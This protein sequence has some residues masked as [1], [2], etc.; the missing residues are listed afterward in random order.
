MFASN[1]SSNAPGWGAAG[2]FGASANSGTNGAAPGG[3]LFGLQPTFGNKRASSS[4]ALSSTPGLFGASQA[5]QSQPQAPQAAAAPG[6]SGG[7]FGAKPG[8]L[9]GSTPGGQAAAG[10]QA[11]AGGL[12][13]GNNNTAAPAPGQASGLFGSN[14]TAA[15]GTQASGGLF[16]SAAAPGNAAASS[17]LFGKTAPAAGGLFGSSNTA[18]PAAGGLFGSS[19][20]AAPAAGGQ[21]GASPAP[22]APANPYNYD[23]SFSSI[24]HNVDQMPRSIT[25]SL[26]ADAGTRKRP[27][28][29]ATPPPRT[30]L[31]S[32][33]GQTMRYLRSTISPRAPD[34][35]MRGIFTPLNYM[36][37]RAPKS[38]SLRPKRLAANTP[39]WEHSDV[40]RLVIRS[41]PRKFHLIDTDKVFSAKRRRVVVGDL[42]T[43]PRGAES[44]EEI[45]E[46]RAYLPSPK[47]KAP[48]SATAPAAAPAAP[49]AAPT[50]PAP[51]AD[52]YWCSPLPQELAKMSPEELA[53]VDCFIVGRVGYGQILYQFPVDLLGLPGGVD[54]LFGQVVRIER[55]KVVVYEGTKPRVG[56]GLNVPATITLE[57]MFPKPGESRHDYIKRLKRQVGM[58]FV[59]YDPITGT[60]VFKVMHFSV[61]GLVDD[62]AALA[63]A[64]RK[65][66]LDEAQ[67]RLEATEVYGAPRGDDIKRQKMTFTSH[68]PGGWDA[69]S[70]TQLQR[71]ALLRKRRLVEHELATQLG[72]YREEQ[73][74]NVNDDVADITIDEEDEEPPSPRIFADEMEDTYSHNDLRYLRQLVTV[75]PTTALSE[76]VDEKAFEPEVK[77]D[78][79]FDTLAVRP[80]LAVSDDWVVQL[81]LS[82]DLNSSLNPLRAAPREAAPPALPAPPAPPASSGM[83]VARMDEILFA[84]FNRAAAAAASA[85]A[86]AA[87]DTAGD[88]EAV[89]P[90]AV[91]PAEDAVTSHIVR[92]VLAKSQVTLRANGFPRFTTTFKIADVEGDLEWEELQVMRLLGLLVE[93]ESGDD[94][95]PTAVAAHLRQLRQRRAVG[96]WLRQ[97]NRHTFSLADAVFECVCAGDVEGAVAAASAAGSH[98]LAALLTVL[99]SHDPAV[100]AAARAQL[101]GEVPASELAVWRILGGE[102]DQV[103]ELPW[104]VALGLRF[105]YGEQALAQLVA[106]FAPVESAVFDALA[107]GVAPLR[108][109][110]AQSRLTPRCRWVASVVLQ[111]RDDAMT[112]E[113]ARLLSAS[114]LWQDAI[115][116]YAAM[117]DDQAV[118]RHVRQLVFGHVE[119]IEAAQPYLVERLRVPQ[120]VLHEARALH[121]ALHGRYVQQGWAL[122]SA[123]LWQ[124]VHDCIAAHVGPAAVVLN[125]AAQRR[126]LLALVDRVP[127]RGLCV[128]HWQHGAGVY[129]DY[130]EMIDAADG[131]G[132]GGGADGARLERLLT[133]LPLHRPPGG[134]ARARFL[135]SVALKIMSK[136]VGDCA[137]ARH[138][139]PARIAALPLGEN[140]RQYF[141][142]R[143]C[144]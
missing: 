125:G 43:R 2:G 6:A 84:D 55:L 32:R 34:P 83:S 77:D 12:F 27:A 85:A 48:K 62:D 39:A 54:S 18:A 30:S 87:A 118:E 66:D 9:F 5:P 101:G 4:G 40:K 29:T 143:E 13:G 121:E 75:L 137:R 42:A 10:G 88:E 24:R 65:Q 133:N 94:A 64:K 7:L 36:N 144:T 47:A 114:E 136:R 141:K 69:M 50:A 20:T 132:G 33:L 140:E 38:A 45:E 72:A 23:T 1:N 63:Q 60:W 61:W 51:R 80:N 76:L 104:S 56:S 97:Y 31:L 59:T 139:A 79:V 11:P 28:E 17:G 134:D 126:E 130:V 119:E 142:A 82:N 100:R 35:E 22:T 116:V 106:E 16:G 93:G 90:D 15:L 115:F 21:F 124:Q 127:S 58:D 111:L 92:A 52:G 91:P 120:T 70:E 122:A 19:N 41:N 71:Q 74:A 98:R 109:R 68:L 123:R 138:A 8:G 49:A 135:Q 99:D 26:F 131:G 3:G 37:L 96:E 81:E 89:A 129:V 46:L 44:D 108:A 103:G 67:R 86:D 78:A 113:F 107:L 53:E 110:L 105:F 117:E 128:P 102:F 73:R 25:E 95:D 112:A 14:N 57:G